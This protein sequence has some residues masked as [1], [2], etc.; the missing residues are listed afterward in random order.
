MT[1]TP[2]HIKW[3]DDRGI[4]DQ[5]TVQVKNVKCDRFSIMGAFR[6][7]EATARASA[8]IHQGTGASQ[9]CHL[10]CTMTQTPVHIKWKDDRGKGD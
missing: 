3:K 2:V 9:H 8:E 4:D 6:P 7:F 10:L 1:Q 5:L